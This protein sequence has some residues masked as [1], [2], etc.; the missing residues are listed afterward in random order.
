MFVAASP[1]SQ[2]LFSRHNEDLAGSF[3]HSF[4]H[5]FIL[6]VSSH[7]LGI[8]KRTIACVD[9]FCIRITQII[10]TPLFVCACFSSTRWFIGRWLID[11]SSHLVASICVVVHVN[12]QSSDFAFI[13][14]DLGYYPCISLFLLLRRH[15]QS[16]AA[17]V[18]TL[19]LLLI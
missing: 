11:N 1:R 15:L 10:I 8:I 3:I 9:C 2:Y 18:N 19:I 7:F 14:C 4:I 6:R 12:P 5:S 16:A 17:E 13:P